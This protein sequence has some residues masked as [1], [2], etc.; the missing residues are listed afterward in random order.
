MGT[1]R[2]I[3]ILCS[4]AAVVGLMTSC[5]ET[6][7]DWG[8]PS[9][10]LDPSVVTFEKGSDT[11]TIT[12]TATRDWVV[13]TDEDW[14]SVQPKSG[15]ASKEAVTVEITV[16]ENTGVDRE[17]SVKFDTG[18]VSKTLTV[19]QAGTG[20]VED[21][22]VYYNDFDKEAATKT[23][24][25]SG[26]S[27]PYLD[28]FEGWKNATGTGAGSEAYAYSGMSVRNNSNSNGNYSDY[29]G[30]GTNN[31]FFGTS[32]YFSV[33]GIALSSNV[34]YTLS[35]GSEK[36]L[37][38]GDSNFKHSEFH[39]Y[40]SNDGKKWVEL[41]YSF[42]DG[43]KEGRW[44]LASSTFTVPSGT[45]QLGI[46]IKTDVASAYRLDD[47]KLSVASA[48]GTAIDF[49]KG[50]E[51]ENGG[52]DGGDT[53]YTK[54]EQKTVKDFIAAAATSKYYRLKGKVS[55]FNSQY[56]SFDLTD[57]TGTIYVY[58]VDNKSEWSSKIKDGGTVEL[59]GKYKQYNSKDEVVNAYIISFE[60]GAETPAT[61]MSIAEALAAE[62]G[63]NA[64]VSG[65]V[66]GTY[67]RGFVITDGKDYL[68]IYDG[69]ECKAALKDNVKVSGTTASYGGLIQLSSPAVTVVSSGN[70]LNLPEPKVLD[71]A[72]LDAYES[73]KIEY[74]T[75][76]GTLSVSGN[77]YNVEVAGASARIGSLSYINSS[78]NAS[79]YDK[80]NVKVTGFFVGLSGSGNKYVNTMVTEL[81]PSASAYLNVS[82]T[83]ISAKAED[84]SVTFDIKAN[85]AWTVTSDNA[86][87]TVE[88]A[89]GDK[90]ATVTVKFA[91]NETDKDV[92][93]NITVATTADVATKSYTIA[94]TH[95]G[96]G[97]AD[98]FA[99]S[100]VWTTV[101]NSSSD[102]AN[103]NGGEQVEVLKLGTSK[104]V[105][106]ATI[107]VP[108]GTKKISFY[109]LAWK[110]KTVQVELDCNDKAVADPV[111]P[112]ANDGCSNT[113]PYTITGVTDADKYTIDV[114][115]LN[116]GQ[117]LAEATTM[118]LK[119]IKVKD[120]RAII[121]G[122]N[123]EK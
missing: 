26:S 35:F 74:I 65:T 105:G 122:L 50:T 66:A 5:K 117:A 103:I 29:E 115:S 37:D 71:G 99:S 114:T 36:Y 119:T 89:S 17:G 96:K 80:T 75:Y 47:L 110:G 30:S 1:K 61:E 3:G 109:A 93:V 27:W 60:E 111:S 45:S 91:A 73:S 41:E 59:A 21:L 63:T 82:S 121:F 84:T 77:Y 40:I 108:A 39:A 95:K 64:I 42:P 79:S 72:A 22:I 24:G 25:T 10:T 12:V 94:L 55:G 51:I 104:K 98:G 32:A 67:Q 49:S 19:N 38:K 112:Q 120:Y 76:E 107:S 8:A 87:Y 68:L 11:Q 6:E 56:C 48:A 85:V 92:N 102:K 83:A 33:T 54:A 16:L 28:Q 31:M 18:L 69:S 116:G 15:K 88:P 118:T 13:S 14:I 106:Y 101:D 90:D 86:A 78:F 53:D 97:A 57:E 62:T 7:E 123:P 43:D 9:V 23:Y 70:E 2:I 58:S 46:Y 113:S 20:S 4:L 34:N 81:K 52:E 100:I 44:D